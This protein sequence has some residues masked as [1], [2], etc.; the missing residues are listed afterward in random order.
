VVPAVAAAK[1]IVLMCYVVVDY[2][3]CFFSFSRGVLLLLDNRFGISDTDVLL[4]DG[5]LRDVSGWRV[6]VCV[7]R[8]SR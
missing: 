6:C 4:F 3:R 8:I 5:G 2:D 7:V 1:D